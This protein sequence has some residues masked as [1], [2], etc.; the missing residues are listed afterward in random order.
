M[1]GIP[2]LLTSNNLS[3][4]GF[5][6]CEYV[7]SP[8]MRNG[9]N[10]MSY[11]G[12]FNSKSLQGFALSDDSSTRMTTRIIILDLNPMFSVDWIVFMVPGGYQRTAYETH[13]GPVYAAIHCPVIA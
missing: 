12:T 1:H 3:S 8:T 11:I 2:Q 6:L 4:A 13:A 9:R 5:P 10:N 7:N